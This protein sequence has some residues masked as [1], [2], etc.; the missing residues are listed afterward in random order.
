M[1]ILQEAL[2]SDNLDY[3]VKTIQDALGI[4]TG[5]VAGQE[6]SGDDFVTYGKLNNAYQ[7]AEFIS[8]WLKAELDDAAEA[9]GSG[10]AS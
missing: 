7:R 10:R 5:D 1:N 2:K 8:S 9:I 6:F 4:E 3:T